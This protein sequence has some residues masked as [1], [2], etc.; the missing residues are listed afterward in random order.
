[1]TKRIRVEL[2]AI[3]CKDVGGDPGGELEFFGEL[4]A[5]RT[6]VNEIGETVET[7]NHI[8]WSRPENEPLE[9]TELSFRGPEPGK[10]VVEVN[11][12]PGDTLSFGGYLMEE[13]PDVWLPIIGQVEDDDYMG[14]QYKVM[15][16]DTLYSGVHE[17]PFAELGQHAEARFR[18]TVLVG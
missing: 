3:K 15:T 7:L 8:F 11:I 12:E 16:Y 9:L 18:T 14:H 13:D 4:H 5:K 17:L 10:G 2:V 1:M 6:F